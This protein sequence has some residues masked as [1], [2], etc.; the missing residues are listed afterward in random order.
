ME[1]ELNLLAARL[2]PLLLASA[3]LLAAAGCEQSLDGACNTDPSRCPTKKEEEPPEPPRI[4]VEPPFGLGFD[5]VSVGCDQ[6]RTFRVENRGGGE[7]AIRLVRLSVDTSSDFDIELAGVDGAE[8][9]AFPSVTSPIHLA[10]GKAFDVVVRYTPSDALPDEGALWIDW[11]DGSIPAEE[12]AAER[13]VL[14]ITTRV[15]GSAVAELVTPTLNFGF[16]PVGETVTLPLKVRN[17]TEGSAVLALEVP[18]FDP[19]SAPH[20]ALAPEPT[21]TIFV[22]PGETMDI[23]VSLSPDHVDWYT[24]TLY[25]PTNDGGR[26]QLVVQ[27]LGT[28][29]QE[30]YFAVLQPSDWRLDF[31]QVRIGASVT[32]EVMVRNLGGQPLSVTATMPQGGD[33]GFSTPIPLGTPLPTIPPLGQV[34]FDVSASP[35][36]GGDVFGEMRFTTNDPTLPEDWLDLQV[37]G[38]APEGVVSPP[39]LAFG[40]IVQGWTSEAQTVHISNGGTGELT[41]TG[42]S[43][44]LGSSSQV[45]FATEPELPVKLRPGQDALPISVL[46]VAQTVGD[47]NATLIVQTDGIASQE[48]RIPITARVV[49][50][51]QG[52]P[53]ANGNPSCAAGHCEI[54]SCLPRYHDT[55]GQY[56]NGCECGEDPGGD[57][58]SSCSSGDNVGPLGDKCSS[59]NSDWVS[60]TGTIHSPSDVD[61]YY[62]YA[63]DDSSFPTCDTTSDS[64]KA[65]VEFVSRSSNVEFCVRRV[66]GEGTCGGENQWSCGY[67]TSWSYDGSY[68]R[69]D[70]SWVTV[71]VRHR[72]GAAPMCGDYTIRFRAKKG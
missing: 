57:V 45:R 49:T 20:F 30:P 8:A 44:E 31:G 25:I 26:P 66:G 60:K 38:L 35:L 12:A 1:L 58:G 70:N 47:A 19:S 15:L 41:I 72:P 42:A 18:L 67:T 16:V 7:V 59:Y 43:F 48:L 52:C 2:A 5:C 40:N 53:V 37:Y 6:T 65:Q 29:I 22:N 39:S 62:F 50:C 33:L 28:A 24:G 3:A 17:A 4:Y 13:E 63:H 11:Y 14:P 21:R 55:D 32:R 36:V 69:D 34:S 46:V 64:F 71:W 68:G 54:G 56:G 27:L 61:L 10:K 51:E 23:P 9:P